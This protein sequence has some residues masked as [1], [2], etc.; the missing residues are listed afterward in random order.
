MG[1]VLGRIQEQGLMAIVVAPRW[2]MAP[3][4]DILLGMAREEPVILG[5][6]DSVCDSLPG[7]RLPRLGTLVAC[8]VEGTGAPSTL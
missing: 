1:K 3:W 4:W 5:K 7:R 8:L 2:Q 6:T